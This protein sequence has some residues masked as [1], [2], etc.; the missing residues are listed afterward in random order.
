[1]R[2]TTLSAPSEAAAPPPASLDRPKAARAS[3]KDYPW[4]RPTQLQATRIVDLFKQWDENGDGQVRP[5][6]SSP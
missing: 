4:P 3:P 2:P 1:M 5:R 6:L